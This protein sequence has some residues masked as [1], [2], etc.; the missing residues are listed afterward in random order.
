MGQDSDT[1]LQSRNSHTIYTCADADSGSRLRIVMDEYADANQSAVVDI[2]IELA[3]TPKKTYRKLPEDMGDGSEGYDYGVGGVGED[4]KAFQFRI[5]LPPNALPGRQIMGRY[6][7]GADLRTNTS[8]IL[9]C[10]KKP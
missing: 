3:E 1:S 10:T 6:W 8:R 7:E 4:G 9:S 2:S 5:Y